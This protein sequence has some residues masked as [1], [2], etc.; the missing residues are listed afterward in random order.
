MLAGFLPNRVK[1]VEL[2]I[3]CFQSA[4]RGQLDTLTTSAAAGGADQ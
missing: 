4:N 3:S 2:K 1:S